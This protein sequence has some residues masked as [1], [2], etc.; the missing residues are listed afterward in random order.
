MGPGCELR[1]FRDDHGL[2][3]SCRATA[4][5]VASSSCANNEAI[6]FGGWAPRSSPWSALL[7]RVVPYAPFYHPGRRAE[8]RTADKQRRIA[9]AQDRLWVPDMRFLTFRDEAP[10]PSNPNLKLTDRFA[11]AM[12]RVVMVKCPSVPGFFPE[13]VGEPLAEIGDV[14][15]PELAVIGVKEHRVLRDPEGDGVAAPVAVEAHLFVHRFSHDVVRRDQFSELPAAGKAGAPSKALLIN[16]AA[17]AQ[18]GFAFH[19]SH[20]AQHARQKVVLGFNERVSDVETAGI[21]GL[22]HIGAL[23]VSDHA[24]LPDIDV[25]VVVEQPAPKIVVIGMGCNPIDA[26]RLAHP[27]P[28]SA[29]GVPQVVDCAD[30]F[31]GGVASLLEAL[32][33]RTPVHQRLE[34]ELLGPVPH[35]EV[36]VDRHCVG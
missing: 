7:G 28:T 14:F 9:S 3:G 19:Q 25:S 27:A 36:N 34:V 8:A 10:D 17:V 26:E 30:A 22:S 16:R 23:H 18:C 11:V 24:S 35:I 6:G 1:P 29:R 15:E 2:L 33:A 31:V 4:Q 5:T 13:V 32:R 20:A 21:V 12:D